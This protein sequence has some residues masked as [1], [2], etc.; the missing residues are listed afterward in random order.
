[1]FRGEDEEDEDVL[2]LGAATVDSG[3]E[4]EDVL[5]LGA[6]TVDSGCGAP[7]SFWEASAD[8]NGMD[9][10]DSDVDLCDLHDLQSVF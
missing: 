4:D 8:L 7:E 1:M 3:E 6:A 9:L 2:Q 5:Q 10:E